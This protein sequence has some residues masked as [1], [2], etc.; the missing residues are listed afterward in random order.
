MV[1][2]DRRD[3]AS[4]QEEGFTVIELTVAM[5]I[6]AGVFLAM[7]FALYSGMNAFGAARQRS[8]FLEISNAE[9]EALRA[10][11]YDK[12]GVSP[13]DFT[14]SPTSGNYPGG[15][16]DGR[17][18]VVV[19][20][21]APAAV[22]TVTSSP[23][24]GIVLPYT[25]RRWVTWS[26][27]SGG[28]THQFKRLHVRVTWTENQRRE[29]TLSLTSV[30]YPGNLGPPVG[31]NSPPTAV[32]VPPSPATG[33]VGDTFTFDASGSSDPDTGDTLAYTWNFGDG[34]S[35]TGLTVTHAYMTEGTKSVA[36]VV[37]DNHGGASTP[38][39]TE[40]SVTNPSGNLP[41]DA[42]FDA[43]PTSG[44][45]PL[46]VSVDGSPSSDP[47]GEDAT[48]TFRWN[49]GD[50]TPEETGV[51][52]NHI[53]NTA[54]TFV[55][56]LTVTD[57][58]GLTDTATTSIVVVPLNCDATGGQFTNT[59]VNDIKVKSTSNTQAEN[60]S[61]TFTATTNVACTSVT[62]VLPLEGGSS[63]TLT[64]A[65]QSTSGNVKTWS[66]SGTITSKFNLGTAQTASV[67]ATD[68]LAGDT[69]SYVFSAHT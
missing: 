63:Y 1:G 16:F 54:G 17:D 50:G 57:Q 51:A 59:A 66:G 13:A 43:A 9:M 53:F 52:R 42:A 39:T 26:D 23:I 19:A 33:T 24:K 56:T 45:A 68:G 30:L 69:F 58:G 6:L 64:L 4:R 40:V 37:T 44:T 31:A 12:V 67:T 61:F 20:T 18:A 5:T 32:I 36:L 62:A 28:T 21:G 2:R 8:A 35:A 10:V 41:P 55:V 65:L 47:P 49:W 11:P 34:T 3:A 46:T 25:V 38:A 27:T 60:S 48:L 15:Q 29:R 14:T 7:A 22:S